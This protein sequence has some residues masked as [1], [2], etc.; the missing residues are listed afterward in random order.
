MD[1]QWNG[2]PPSGSLTCMLCRGSVPYAKNETQHFR[3]H[4]QHHHGV[5]YHHEVL[6]SVNVLS[7][8][9]LR[10]IV[11]EYE[12]SGDKS[13]LVGEEDSQDVV[14]LEETTENASNSSVIL[15]TRKKEIIEEA[16]VHNC[17][18]CNAKFGKLGDLIEHVNEHTADDKREQE[19]IEMNRQTLEN[20]RRRLIEEK[21]VIKQRKEIERK[22]LEG[23]KLKMQR[24]IQIKRQEELSHTDEVANSE[25]NM[26][27]DVEKRKVMNETN[28]RNRKDVER[29]REIAEMKATLK[30]IRE[31]NGLEGS[32]EDHQEQVRGVEVEEHSS[33]AV[34]RESRPV[35]FECQE[36]PYTT[37]RNIELKLHKLSHTGEKNF[38]CQHCDEK[39]YLDRHLKRHALKHTKEFAKKFNL[40]KAVHNEPQQ[41]VE[42]DSSLPVQPYEDETAVPRDRSQSSSHLDQSKPKKKIKI[43]KSHSAQENIRNVLSE[44]SNPDS[45]LPVKSFKDETMVPNH[46]SQF[47][48]NLDQS[49]PKKKIKIPKVESA[50]GNMNVLSEDSTQ[51]YPRQKSRSS[52]GR[53]I[54]EIAANSEYFQ[55]FPNQ[56]KKGL[57]GDDRFDSLDPTMPEGWKFR[58]IRRP[59]GRVDK[60]FCSPDY[61]VFRS[62]KAMVEYMKSMG[63][64]S[65]EEIDRAEKGEGRVSI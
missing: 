14:E 54:S 61:M 55:Q 45:S 38:A 2:A 32:L 24:E 48:S 23:E 49:M 47:S 13:E 12:R 10:R 18:S 17:R 36:C 8:D 3:S 34:E 19:K 30:Q 63:R 65:Q 6:L 52:L 42:M 15:P 57:E 25:E 41:F 43:P 20:E 64:Y 59:N 58:E 51:D 16:K 56:I 28:A 40:S 11:Q 5:F 29:S 53:G 21:R 26:K 9:Y 60:E 62:K 39:F 31:T 44:D 50:Q 35:V 33:Q 4:L 27:M 1:P 46:L 37:K 22:R 7:K